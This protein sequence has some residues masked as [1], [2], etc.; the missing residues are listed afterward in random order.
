M[1]F[2]ALV[3]V[4][5]Y[6]FPEP[7]AYSSN[8]STL[9]DSARN[10]EGVMIGSVIRDDVSKIEISWR[11]LTVEQWARIQNCFRQSSGGSFTNLVNFFDQSVGG[12]ITKE[13]YVSDRKSGMWRRDPE[14]G[15]VLGW[16]DCSLSLIQV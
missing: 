5:G 15:D 1:A 8:T 6:D 11:Y 16:T 4:D 2:R 13:M 9:V 10:T 12:W 7:S 3:S 14:T